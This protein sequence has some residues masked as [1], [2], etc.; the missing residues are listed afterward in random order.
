MLRNF[1]DL[2]RRIVA[3][4]D[5]CVGGQRDFGK[6]D[7]TR[8]G[9]GVGSDNLEGRDHGEAHVRGPAAGTV[10]AVA[11]VDIHEGRLVAL[12]PS[13]L[14]CDGAACCWP[15]GPVAEGFMSAAWMMLVTSRTG[16]VIVMMC[17]RV[18]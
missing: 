18:G 13:R 8:V 3:G 14:Q 4:L 7:G 1:H 15:E 6:A 17:Y 9:V 5:T 10:G 11:Q 2:D 12:K 16:R